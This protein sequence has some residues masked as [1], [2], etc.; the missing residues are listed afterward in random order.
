MPHRLPIVVVAAPSP[1][2]ARIHRAASLPGGPSPFFL[3]PPHPRA[4]LPAA[5]PYPPPPR[6]APG[7]AHIHVWEC[8]F[9]AVRGGQ[10]VF[11]HGWCH[12][13][14]AVRLLGKNPAT[15]AAIGGCRMS[16]SRSPRRRRTFAKT[17]GGEASRSS[18][19]SGSAGTQCCTFFT[20]PAKAASSIA[21]GFL[22]FI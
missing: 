7:S 10:A 19:T 12:P 21:F 13:L 6:C 15:K 4:S 3:P 17:A 16:N 5:S 18:I 11:S 2:L 14:T 22:F 20:S 9:S 1:L 8:I